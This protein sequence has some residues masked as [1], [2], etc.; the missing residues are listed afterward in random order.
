MDAPSTAPNDPS[1]HAEI[2]AMVRQLKEDLLLVV[3]GV[4]SCYPPE[5]DICNFYAG[6][7]HQCL[8]TRLKEKA[9]PDLN[10]EDSRTILLWV[11]NYYPG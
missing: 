4:R 2:T 1:M 10:E 11:N 3:D 6:L 5:M 8:S 9:E 7:Y